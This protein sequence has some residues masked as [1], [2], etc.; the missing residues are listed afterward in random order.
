MLAHAQTLRNLRNWIAA[1][2]DLGDRVALEL[3]GEIAF[4]RHS[5]FASK[6]REEIVH[7]SRRFWWG[8]DRRKHRDQVEGFAAPLFCKCL[9]LNNLG[10]PPLG[11]IFSMI[12]RAGC[13]ARH[14]LRLQ[15]GCM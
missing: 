7:K 3:L 12:C 8:R 2:N 15:R 13:E 6:S 10:V 14:G 1:F 5:L 11:T 9:K 4:A